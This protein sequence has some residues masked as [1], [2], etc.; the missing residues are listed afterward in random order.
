MPHFFADYRIIRIFA[1]VMA[2]INYRREQTRFAHKGMR[3]DF[4]GKGRLRTLTSAA[5]S[6]KF[7]N[8]QK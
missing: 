4:T 8:D 6:R 3:V 2:V 1:N 5:E 7:T